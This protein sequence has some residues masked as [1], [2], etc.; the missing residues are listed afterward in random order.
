MVFSSAL[1]LFAFLPLTYILYQGLRGIKAK[2]V[3]LL[4]ASLVFYASGR[5]DWLLLLFFS[6]LCN[7]IAGLFMRK[8]EKCRKIALVVAVCI[9][10]GLLGVFKYLNFFTE[11]ISLIP[12]FQI[13]PTNIALPIGISFFTFQGMSYVIDVYKNP[14]GATTSFSKVLLYISFFP[15]LVAG[16]I[17]KYSDIADQI[18]Q[19]KS[20]PELTVLGIRRFVLGLVK[21]LFFA[22]GLGQIADAVYGLDAGMLDGRLVW[23]G[24]ICYTLQIYYDFSAYSDMAIGLGRMFGFHINENFAHPYCSSSV[25]EFWRRWHISLSSWFKEY[26]YIPLGG[27]R[28]GVARARWNRLIVFFFTGMWH[29]ANWTFILWGLWHG[30]FLFLEDFFGRKKVRIPVMNH[31]YTMLV[32]AMGFMLFRADT[33]GQAFVMLKAMYTGFRFSPE[34]TI[35]LRNLLTPQT[36]TTILVGLV[37]VMPVLDFCKKQLQKRNIVIPGVVKLSVVMIVFLICV[38]KLAASSFNPFI[39]TQF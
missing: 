19:R 21:K 34:S 6:A 4:I 1:F 28:L 33:I 15:Q 26:L 14:S 9:N 27:N 25:K 23:L 5:L 18:D 22:N 17:V 37:G 32:V 7:Y 8:G 16:P 13:T 30:L 29:G 24:V 2:N 31:L 39:Y 3:L 11:T 36:L 20:T 38:I 12:F 10:L 35:F